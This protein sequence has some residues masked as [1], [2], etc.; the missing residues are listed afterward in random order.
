MIDKFTQL[1][2]NSGLTKSEFL[3]A[4]Q[5]SN[6]KFTR[7]ENKDV[8]ISSIDFKIYKERLENYLKNK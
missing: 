5:I 6:T 8:E 2:E 3:Q 1:F 7:Y 4:V